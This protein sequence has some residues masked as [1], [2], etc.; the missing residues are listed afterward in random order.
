MLQQVFTCLPW[1]SSIVR[2]WQKKAFDMQISSITVAALLQLF[3]HRLDMWS[4]F[5]APSSITISSLTMLPPPPPPPTGFSCASFSTLTH[6][7]HFGLYIIIS[8]TKGAGNLCWRARKSKARAKRKRNP[9]A[10]GP[11]EINADWRSSR[12]KNCT[13]GTLLKAWKQQSRAYNKSALHFYHELLCDKSLRHPVGGASVDLNSPQD[14]TGIPS[15]D[16]TLSHMTFLV[17]QELLMLM[18]C[19]VSDKPSAASDG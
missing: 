9:M 4:W 8:N 12:G 16:N 7:I 19:F 14:D 2:W 5:G 11:W 17:H 13:S 15:L 18:L 10:G 1:C 3:L 6:L